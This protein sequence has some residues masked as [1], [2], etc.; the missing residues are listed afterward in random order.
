MRDV[1]IIGAHMITFGKYLEQSIKDLTAWTVAGCLK[2]AN[3][4]KNDIQAIWFAN[5]GWE[6]FKGQSTIR[7]QVALRPM[8]ID[9]I[10]ITN[11]ENACAGGSTAFHHAWLGVASGLYDIT[12]AI[13]AEKLYLSNKSA[14]FAAFLGGIDIENCVEIA[15]GLSVFGLTPDEQQARDAFRLKYPSGKTVSNKRKPKLKNR[16]KNAKDKLVVAINLG[17]KIGYGNVMKLRRIAAGDHSPFMDIYGF[18]ARQHMRRYGTTVEQLAAIASK[19]H[20]HST[21]NPAAQYRFEVPPADVL[22]DRIISFPITRSMCAPIGDGSASAILC[23]EKRVRE[24]GLMKRAVKVRASVLGSGQAYPFGSDVPEIG[25]RLA[26][27]AYETAGLG[28]E[29]I[30]LAEVH[31]A[32]AFGELVQAENLGFCP[33]GEGGVLAENGETRI[34]GK[35]PIN[36]SGGLVSRGHPIGASGLAQIYELVTQLRGRACKRQVEHARLAIAENG[37]GALGSEEAAMCMHILEAPLK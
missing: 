24:L 23:S 36:T 37:G 8:G 35:I 14:I 21:L 34:G 33:K 18:A 31:D 32:T 4:T 19:S 25:E 17:E 28:P 12:M 29:D 2:D 20:F 3:L 6:H 30:D 27:T 13:G 7:G 9:T 26:N 16:V 5:S 10:P 1:Y 22:A 15:E 11:V